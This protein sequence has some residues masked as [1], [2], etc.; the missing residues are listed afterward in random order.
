[1]IHGLGDL[2]DVNQPTCSEM[3]LHPNQPYTFRKL[4]EVTLLR[5]PQSI[6][7]EERDDLF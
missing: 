3:R 5:S 6:L 2:N 1:M 4:Q 7:V